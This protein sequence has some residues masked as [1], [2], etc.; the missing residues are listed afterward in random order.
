VSESFR[1]SRGRKVL[2]RASANE[3]GSVGHLVVDARRREVAAIVVG[4]GKNAKIVEWAQL[5][6]FGP[7]AVIVVD[8]GA[9][10]PPADRREHA[11]ASGKLEM[12]GKRTLSEW[13]NGLGEIED[14]TFDL[15]TGALD[16]LVIGERRVPA[17]FLLGSGSYAV[18]LEEP[19]DPSS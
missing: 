19:K 7:D 4:R 2:S 9:L 12:L 16:D 13:G 11:A 1:R 17:R 10:R 6:G 3:L 15:D 18:V 14:V 5:S 8:E